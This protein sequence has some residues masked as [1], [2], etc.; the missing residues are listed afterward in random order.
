MKAISL[1]K[2]VGD[3]CVT[4][5]AITNIEE[6]GNTLGQLASVYVIEIRLYGGALHLNDVRIYGY[7]TGDSVRNDQTVCF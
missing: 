4:M 2:M 1:I 5:I 3:A 6:N 7:A